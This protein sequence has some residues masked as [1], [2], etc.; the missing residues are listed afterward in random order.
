MN[1]S[2]GPLNPGAVVR[3]P[4]WPKLPEAVAGSDS[5]KEQQRNAQRLSDSGCCTH[6][7]HAVVFEVD[8]RHDT[9]NFNRQ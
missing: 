7:R 4:L 9:A 5:M 6:V 1:L 2:F 3:V 8:R